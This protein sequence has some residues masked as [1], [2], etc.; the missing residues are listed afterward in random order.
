LVVLLEG[1]SG[2]DNLLRLIL[3]FFTTMALAI[4]MWLG[5]QLTAKRV[6]A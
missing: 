3:M 6:A 1:F 5:L 2:G 4:A